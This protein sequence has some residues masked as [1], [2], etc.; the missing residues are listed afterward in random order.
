VKFNK[1]RG[2]RFHGFPLVAVLN[3]THGKAVALGIRVPVDVGVVVVHVPV[4]GIGTTL[5]SRP[6]VAVVADIV[7][8]AIRIAVACGERGKSGSLRYP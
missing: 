5:R 1:K 8:G 7:E 2:I 3:A 6:P 4:V